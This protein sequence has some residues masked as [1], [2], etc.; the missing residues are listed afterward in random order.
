MTRDQ[1]RNQPKPTST[2]MFLQEIAD[3]MR[4]NID[5]GRRIYH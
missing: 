5:R 1:N 3:K 2:I 4:I